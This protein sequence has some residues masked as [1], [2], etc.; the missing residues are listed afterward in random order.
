MTDKNKAINAPAPPPPREISR[1]SVQEESQVLEMGPSAGSQFV[2]WMASIA[3]TFSPWGQDVALRDEQLRDFWPSESNLSG[4]VYTCGI[5]NANYEWELE[6]PQRTVDAVHEVLNKAGGG[7]WGT[8]VKK[9]SIDLYTQD[10]GAF[11]E[12]IRSRNNPS[13]PILGI[14]N[15]DSARCMRTGNLEYPVIY[16]DIKGERHKMP[17]YSIITLEEFPTPIEKMFNVQYCATTRVLRSAQILRDMAIY[18]GEKAGG[19]FSE[20]IH[21]LGGVQQTVIE[22][23]ETRQKE[24]ADNQG[25]VRYLGPMLIASLDPQSTPSVATLNMKSLPENFSYD[26]ELKWYISS[27]ALGFGRDYQDFAP[28]PGRGIGSA[29]E[30]ETLHAKSRGK[31]PAAFMRL[32]ED[33][34]NFHGVMPKT[35]TFRFKDQDLGEEKANADIKKTRAEEREIRIASGEINDVLARQLAVD[36]GDLK[37]EYLTLIGEGDVTPVTPVEGSEKPENPDVVPS[38]DIEETVVKSRR[39]SS[40]LLRPFVYLS[41]SLKHD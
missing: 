24:T 38:Q 21:I 5:T 17:W 16:M 39:G 9:L 14:D 27:L 2:L 15:L 4:A 10:N 33:A 22:D 25:L 23:L 6:G 18:R 30:G 11:I 3:D 28:L 7:S 37:Q 29:R 12:I 36:D 31:G 1:R 13:A 35:V 34:F 26:E 41:R 8:F 19:R 40:V 32:L 20:A